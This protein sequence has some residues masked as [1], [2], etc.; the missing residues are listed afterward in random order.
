MKQIGMD[1]W[2]IDIMLELFKIIRA[3]NGSETTNVVERITG[4]NQFHL[5]NLR[6]IT[7]KSLDKKVSIILMLYILLVYILIH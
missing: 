1:N 5:H 7:L 3:G 2:S 6:E 4:R